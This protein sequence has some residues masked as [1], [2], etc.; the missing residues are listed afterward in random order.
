VPHR[1]EP[2]PTP[3]QI[4]RAQD[5]RLFAQLTQEAEAPELAQD[6]EQAALETRFLELAKRL[7]EHGSVERVLARLLARVHK[8][9][10]PRAVRTFPQ[11]MHRDRDRDRGQGRERPR[12]AGREREFIDFRVSW[13]Q[14]GGADARRMLAMIC[15]RGGIRGSDVG[16]IRIDQHSAIVGVDSAVAAAFE[17]AVS[18]TDH[19][20]PHIQIRREHRT[21][22]QG[23]DNTRGSRDA[24]PHP[25]RSK[26][27]KSP[28]KAPKPSKAARNR[29]TKRTH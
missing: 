21:N 20:E 23:R 8:G 3:E 10:Q 6:E 26:P 16:A 29:A 15:R 13:G 22:G 5:E 2:V 14:E 25:K 7:V 1:F 19:R 17:R 12:N 4:V 18:K 28:F 24:R 9:V 27:G 11:G